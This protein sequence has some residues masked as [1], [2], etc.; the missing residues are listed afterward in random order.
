MGT[1]ASPQWSPDGKEIVFD[2]GLERDWRAPRALFVIDSDGG[3]PRPLLFDHFSNGRPIWSHDG[4]WIYFASDRSGD[5]QVWKIRKSGGTPVQITK[6]G[7]FAAQ[8]SADGKYLYY[9]KTRVDFPEIWL[10]P[11]NGG[12]ETPIYPGIRPHDWAAWQLLDHGILF[13]GGG[14]K[15]HSELSFYDFTKQAIRALGTLEKQPFWLTSTRDGRSVIFDQPG[16]EESHVVLLE[17]FH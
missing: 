3:S 11:T 15:G 2:V 6:E 13:A 17:N 9:S 4:R 14:E 10:V 16:Q 12:Y 1:A 7:G 5:W 8:E